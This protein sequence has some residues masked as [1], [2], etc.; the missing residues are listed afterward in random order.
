MNSLIWTRRWKRLIIIS[1]TSIFLCF[2][3]TSSAFVALAQWGFTRLLP[4]DSG[5][6]VDSIV[7]LGRG[8][9]MR[10]QRVET[11]QELWRSQRASS[12][13][14]SGMNDAIQ[15]VEQLKLHNIPG[16]ALSGESCSES[17]EENMQF[18]GVLLKP[19]GVKR[20]LLVTDL[21]H[22]MRSHQI[23]E[24]A[25]FTVLSH[26]TILP[27]RWNSRQR[28]QVYLRES[29]GL[30]GYGIKDQFQKVNPTETSGFQPTCRV[31][32]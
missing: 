30:I 29:L 7:V 27:E 13:F 9:D 26:P 11:A 5:Q 8:I 4:V 24:A 17:T 23:F 32:G 19:R 1:L 21:P 20:I 28:A 3:F 31:D 15:I 10:Q 22:A 2:F 14:A 16:L 12:I 25:G 18:T 6:A